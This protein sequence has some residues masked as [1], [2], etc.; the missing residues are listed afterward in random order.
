MSQQR[1]LEQSAKAE[2]V[3][4]RDRSKDELLRL[5]EEPTDGPPPPQAGPEAAEAYFLSEVAAGE[6]L[7][8][9]GPS[10]YAEAAVHF[11]RALSVYPAPTELMGIYR[12]VRP[13]IASASQLIAPRR[14]RPRSSS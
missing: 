3:R 11:F 4:A 5:L 8:L 14:S 1:K 7:T 12:K 2:S 10:K 9:S 6:Q 13:R